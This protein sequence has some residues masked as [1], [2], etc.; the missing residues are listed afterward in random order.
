MTLETMAYS[1]SISENAKQ[2]VNISENPIPLLIDLIKKEEY[3]KMLE[4]I[5]VN[6]SYD[7]NVNSFCIKIYKEIEPLLTEKS[8]AEAIL[9]LS[10][11]LSK[12]DIATDPDIHF[13]AF[14][15]NLSVE[16]EFA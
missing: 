4:W 2:S 3:R 10:E 11:Y 1:G 15:I 9:I 7:V 12:I 5:D 16:V 14:I 8:V 13:A 6:A